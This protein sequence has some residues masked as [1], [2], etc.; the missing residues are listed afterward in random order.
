[1]KISL[2]IGLAT[3]LGT[4]V[5]GGG[6]NT[7]HAENGNHSGTICKN[8]N[9]AEVTDIDYLTN[10]T[11]NLN[12]S[13]RFVICPLV[14]APTPNA[15]I[16]YVGGFAASGQTILC[17]LYSYDQ[18]GNFLGGNSFPSAMTGNFYVYLSIPAVSS[19][20]SWGTSSVLCVLPP[21]ASGVIYDVDVVQ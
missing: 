19:G 8:Y 15:K 9:A 10:G 16:V 21:S 17:T 20:A 13:P 11:R 2:A 18:V 14:T 7:A 4:F 6:A 12:M 5:L 3:T 1:M